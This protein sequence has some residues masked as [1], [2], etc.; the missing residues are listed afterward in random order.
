MP[1]LA[2][3]LSVAPERL[4]EIPERLYLRFALTAMPDRL[5]LFAAAGENSDPGPLAL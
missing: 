3:N 1:V 2:Q 5:I 4:T